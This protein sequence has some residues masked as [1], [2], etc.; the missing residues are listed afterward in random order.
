MGKE[1]V[2]PFCSCSLGKFLELS[3]R[4]R[5]REHLVDN[6]VAGVLGRLVGCKGVGTQCALIPPL[7]VRLEFGTRVLWDALQTFPTF[8]LSH[9]PVPYGSRAMS[10]VTRHGSIGSS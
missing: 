7:A 1:I 2:F 3:P 6:I 9:T 8:L 10:L 5:K 4:K